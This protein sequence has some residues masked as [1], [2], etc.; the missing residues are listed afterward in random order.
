MA[1]DDDRGELLGP[2]LLALAEVM[3]ARARAANLAAMARAEGLITE[4]DVRCAQLA[5]ERCYGG[6]ALAG[7][8]TGDCSCPARC[9]V[10][11]CLAGDG[12]L[13]GGAP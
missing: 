9:P 2:A 7:T 6:P 13:D 12:V 11:H 5:C 3:L 1:D 10:R 8:G 4:M